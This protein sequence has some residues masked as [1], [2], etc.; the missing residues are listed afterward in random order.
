[1]NIFTGVTYSISSA[2]ANDLAI[3]GLYIPVAQGTPR[4]FSNIDITAKYVYT[5]RQRDAAI[6]KGPR[7]ALASEILKY[8]QLLH[9]SGEKL[10]DL[11]V[12]T[13]E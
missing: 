8:C 3:S 10:K 1:V 9:N 2:V 5:P 12:A 11:Q 7:D 13:D 4:P 6:V